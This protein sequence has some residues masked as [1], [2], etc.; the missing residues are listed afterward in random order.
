MHIVGTKY[1]CGNMKKIDLNLFAVIYAC[2]GDGA[3][4][5]TNMHL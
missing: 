1:C 3:F 2:Y 4:T 5:V